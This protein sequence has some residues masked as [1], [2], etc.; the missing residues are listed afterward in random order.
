MHIRIPSHRLLY[1]CRKV[2][3]FVAAPVKGPVVRCAGFTLVE[4]LAVVALVAV[5]AALLLPAAGAAMEKGRRT[6]CRGN[7]RQL[8]ARAV[9]AAADMDGRLPAQFANPA[10]VQG[11]WGNEWNGSGSG[12]D[13]E[14]T[15]LF[16]SRAA[17]EDVRVLRCRSD[18]LFYPAGG[19][20]AASYKH[21]FNRPQTAERRTTGDSP[22]SVIVSEHASNHGERHSFLDEDE[23]NYAT[24]DGA[25]ARILPSEIDYNDVHRWGTL[26]NG[27]EDGSGPLP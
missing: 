6:E 25:V 15:S 20:G 12:S 22:R 5:L 10:G 4:L 19:L 26:A 13:W 14:P 8:A 11:V 1:W 7:L 17:P 16:G 27:I 18:D 23:V 3:A 2:Y 24:L 21:W 9:L